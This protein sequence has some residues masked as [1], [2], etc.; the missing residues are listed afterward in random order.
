MPHKVIACICSTNL[1]S[2]LLY[3]CIE[4]IWTSEMQ[5]ELRSA[6]T[7]LLFPSSSSTSPFSS[8]PGTGPF[9]VDMTGIPKGTGT[10]TGNIADLFER[11]ITLPPDYVVTYRQ[12]SEELH[13]GGVYLRLFLKQPTYKL[14]N[15][16]YFIEK[17][18]EFWEASFNAQVPLY[19]PPST[20]GAVNN[21]NNNVTNLSAVGGGGGGCV[22]YI[23]SNNNTDNT[24]TLIQTNNNNNNN[25]EVSIVLAKEDFLTLITSCIICILKAE[26]TLIDHII[27]WGFIKTLYD[28]LTRALDW[29]RRGSPVVSI[30]R[31]LHELI[32]HTH[33]IDS[34]TVIPIDIIL[35]LTRALDIHSNSIHTNAIHTNT[36]HTN[37]INQS[38]NS[39][40]SNTIHTNSNN[41]SN[42]SIHSNT[43]NQSNSNNKSSSSIY[44]LPPELP[45]DATL[46]V[47]L[48]RK[49]FIYANNTNNNSSNK[50]SG[51]NSSIIYFI[52][53]AI[54][55]SLP[56]YLL[57]YIIQA[58]K[59]K[60]SK[61]R[62]ASALLIYAVD[63]IKYILEVEYE[64]TRELQCILEQHSAWRDYCDQSH[65]LYI[66]VCVYL[67]V[68]YTYYC[69]AHIPI[70]VG[71]INASDIHYPFTLFLCILLHIHA[72]TCPYMH[73]YRVKRRPIRTSYKTPPEHG[74]RA[75]SLTALPLIQQ[76]PQHQHRKPLY[77]PIRLLLMPMCLMLALSRQHRLIIFNLNLSLL[78]LLLHAS[79]LP[80]PP[81]LLLLLL[82]LP[83]QARV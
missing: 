13:I 68:I 45:V 10:G 53:C 12:L 1:Y 66:T 55:A 31:I 49:L 19:S 48:L 42:N 16:L 18:V 73:I 78:T 14:S 11:G 70:F 25:D 9:P 72:Y 56:Q 80:L 76:L 28:Y 67:G 38:N 32:H 60:L 6:L 33:A 50:N 71:N 64:G 36:I 44:T 39:I 35:Q 54:N 75:Y 34:L 43:I 69:G 37:S 24:N 5:G 21:I 61:V 79:N 20:A 26:P 8:P 57:T 30:I 47:D 52:Q 59:T 77:F 65:D 74:L 17:L 23:N 81:P 51:D 62:N 40:H 7:T 22:D 29:D 15:S 83:P 46:I 58:S 4:L 82:L 41:Q 3:M 27:S 2:S 63:V